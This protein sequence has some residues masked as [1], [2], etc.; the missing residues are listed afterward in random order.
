MV[1]IK[2]PM[3]TSRFFVAL[4]LVSLTACSTGAHR[5]SPNSTGN[6]PETVIVTYHVKMGK[7]A[8]MEDV[9][10]RA[11][12]IYQN[13]DMVLKTPHIIVRDKESGNKTRMV[14][15]FTWATHSGPEHPPERVK[16]IWNEMQTLCENRDGHRGLDGG[17][18]ELLT[19]Q[20]R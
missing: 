11:W 15:I 13:E 19:P 14:E 10:K 5:D 3:K 2:F 4:V 12:D 1:V 16:A 8:A 18:V 6:G 17:E 7:E 20:A 9:L